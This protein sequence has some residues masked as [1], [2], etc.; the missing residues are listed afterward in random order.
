MRRK[1]TARSTLE[2][3]KR[4]AKRWL[5]A[6]RENDSQARS[7]LQRIWPDA[8][9]SPGLRDVQHALALEHGVSG[10]TALKGNLGEPAPHNEPPDLLV[11]RF[12]RNACPD[13][14]VRG[15]PA[16]VMA[17]HTAGRLL[18]QHPEIARYSLYTAIV[19]GEIDTVKRIL[20]EQPQLAREVSSGTGYDR[21][22]SGDFED[23]F[24]DAGPI[25][26]EPLL[27]LCFTR[28]SLP[29][30]NDNAV[31][32]AKLLLDHG[33]NPN[34]Y[35]KAG[36]SFY[37]PLVGVIGEGEESRPPHP[38]RNELVRL[39]L[40]RGASS[41]DAQVIY[42]THFK[43][44][45]QW[46]LEMAYSQAV[47]EGRESDWADPNWPMF[48]MGGYGSGARF[49]LGGAIDRNNLQLAQWMLEHGANPNAPP[50][51]RKTGHTIDGSERS[52]D[53]SLYEVALLKGSPEMA[54]LLAR[55]GAA[56]RA[57]APDGAEAFMTAC[58]RMDRKK[59][60]ALLVGHPEYLTSPKPM[61][62]AATRDRADVAALLLDLGMSPDIEDPE[63]GK[64]HPLHV[65]A[66]NDALRVAALLIERG[67]QI[68]PRETRH[69]ITPLWG[70]IWGQRE[71]M[72]DFLRPRSRDVWG[73]TFIG[74]VERLREVL[75]A[76]PK[77]ATSRGENE[78]PLMWLPADDASAMEIAEMFLAGGADP[79][80]RNRQGQTAADL[81]GVRGLDD[82]AALLR[83]KE[84]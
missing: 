31:E 65:A 12:L 51:P 18:Q 72:I 66:Y 82:V 1:L 6:I 44:D 58:L 39:L 38:R 78:T 10:W 32:I 83:S 55:Y 54:E 9:P 81:A 48:D 13:H 40:E 22:R 19:C 73:L 23:L 14:H 7:R 15:G 21:A 3:L 74:D 11:A 77:L 47:S 17:L 43:G 16:H 84:G 79:N 33:A 37:T 70:A 26:W 53:R 68:D 27:Y 49:L 75:R 62:V 29:A 28:L 42:N 71:R 57:A 64:Q 80:V 20:A 46:F 5:K 63:E 25:R 50:P 8:P 56:R 60:E 45:V 67:G 61:T 36:D 59:A 52:S 76:E 41:H 35:F 34:A 69:G 4:E 30:A 2:N 24:R